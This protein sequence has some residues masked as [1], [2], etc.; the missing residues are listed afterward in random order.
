MSLPCLKIY[1]HLLVGPKNHTLC[2]ISIF[3]EDCE[4][5]IVKTEIQY[6]V[7]WLNVLSQEISENVQERINLLAKPSLISITPNLKP[8]PQS[9]VS[10]E[11]TPKCG[12]VEEACR[13]FFYQIIQ[14]NSVFKTSMIIQKNR[15]VNLTRIT[16]NY[17]L[18]ESQK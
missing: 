8:Y 15:L 3:K 16:S 1:K 12:Y 18:S 5:T 6:A 14:K 2:F 13:V 10:I 9:H 4:K 11:P 7:S 17:S